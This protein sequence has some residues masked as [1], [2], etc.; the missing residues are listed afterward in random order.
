MKLFSAALVLAL[1]C[2]VT[3]AP[4]PGPVPYH[5]FCRS[6]WLFSTPCAAIGSTLQQR[7]GPQ[8]CSRLWKLSLQFGVSDS[9]DHPGE[10]HFSRRTRGR[11]SQLQVHAT[12]LSGGCR[13]VANSQSIA[14]TSL[15]D[16]GL[17]YCNLYTL[18]SESGLAAQPDFMEMTNEW[19]CLGFGLATFQ[20][21]TW[22]LM[23]IWLFAA[24]CEQIS[25]VLQQQIKALSPDVGCPECHYNLVSATP[26]GLMANHTSLDGLTAET[27]TFKFRSTVLTGG[28]M[29]SAQ[30]QSVAFSSLLDN[31]VNY[32]N[33]YT[34]VKVSGLA[35][36]PDFMETTNEWACLGYGL[37]TCKA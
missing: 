15:L 14:F 27:L 31:G 2:S 21:V 10:P 36:L 8:S 1:L 37:A 6:I 29:V 11:N 33:L 30:S 34:L 19:A 22:I 9:D 5:A 17:N 20:N 28:C 26:L 12:V 3:A 13:V 32:C 23:S 24:P 16:N 35:E 4:I 25:A 7:Y 18:V